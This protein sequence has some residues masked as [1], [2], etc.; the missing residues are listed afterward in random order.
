L[1]GE[2]ELTGDARSAVVML[3]APENW[4]IEVDHVVVADDDVKELVADLWT[5]DE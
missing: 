2:N 4:P 5:G 1:D 3:L